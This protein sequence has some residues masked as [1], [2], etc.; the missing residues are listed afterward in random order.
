L[1]QRNKGAGDPVAGLFFSA[2]VF[3]TLQNRWTEPACASRGTSTALS[4][5]FLKG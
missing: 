1:R 3:S 4:E 2:A 5:R